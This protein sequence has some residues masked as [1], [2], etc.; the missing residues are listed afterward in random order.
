MID[1]WQYLNGAATE[2]NHADMLRCLNAFLTLLHPEPE[3]VGT[4]GR[5]DSVDERPIAVSPF[6][7]LRF[8]F[9]KSQ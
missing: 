4:E 2:S 6:E 3:H 7:R 9:K 5:I 8:V 1:F